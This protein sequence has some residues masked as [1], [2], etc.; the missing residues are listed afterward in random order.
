MGNKSAREALERI[1][2][3]ICM[4]EALGIRNIPQHQR[5]KIKGYT[6]YDD[7]I[8]FHHIKEKSEGGETSL[9]NGSLVR[10]Y[11]H[12]WLHSLPYHQKEQVNN[13][14]QKYKLTVLA[15]TA[16][17]KY[18]NLVLEEGTPLELELDPTDCMIIPLV[19]EKSKDIKRN[20]HTKYDR[21]KVK[22]DFQE[23]MDREVYGV[24]RHRTHTQGKIVQPKEYESNKT[25]LR[26]SMIWKLK[27][28]TEGHAQLILMTQTMTPQER[29]EEF[30][31]IEEFVHYLDNY[32]ENQR[33]LADYDRMKQ[34]YDRLSRSG[35]IRK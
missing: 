22:R 17:D 1:F 25:K 16:K 19:H 2:G 13:A 35:F 26:Q 32:D 29:R 20:P 23:Q 11:N 27:N 4:I 34:L 33:K 9:E 3:K 5:R 30:E 31:V 10:G 14:I 15:H 24:E 6:K 12:R 8:T 18:G 28:A 21:A 7:I